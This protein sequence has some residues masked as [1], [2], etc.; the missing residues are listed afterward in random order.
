MIVSRFFFRPLPARRGLRRRWG[1]QRPALFGPIG[2]KSKAW[3]QVSAE[4]R[5]EPGLGWSLDDERRN[6]LCHQKV[7]LTS[8]EPSLSAPGSVVGK[9]DLR[10]TASLRK[11]GDF[12]KRLVVWLCFERRQPLVLAAAGC[13]GPWTVNAGPGTIYTAASRGADHTST[14]YK[15]ERK[16][17][18]VLAAGVG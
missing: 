6:E 1:L 4:G 2:N 5:A 9:R 13:S 10:S 16:G 3:M 18:D 7:F 17:F 11:S 14:V 12:M 8:G 15:L